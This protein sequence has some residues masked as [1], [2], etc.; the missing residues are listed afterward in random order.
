MS[1]D[2]DRDLETSESGHEAISYVPTNFRTLKRIIPYSLSCHL[3]LSLMCAPRAS[4]TMTSLELAHQR[5][6]AGLHA[7]ARQ[8][9]FQIP[10]S[11]WGLCSVELK[12]HQLKSIFFWNLNCSISA[13]E[14]YVM[15]FNRSLVC[16]SKLAKVCYL[17]N[18]LRNG[19]RE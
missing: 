11:S 18:T 6:G 9:G 10:S 15:Y 13:P 16:T 4:L 14:F 19:Y 17:R 8:T 1:F 3:H 5:R 12:L 7:A 2:R